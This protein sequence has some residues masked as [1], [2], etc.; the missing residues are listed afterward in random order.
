M[1]LAEDLEKLAALRRSGALTP[2]EF[3]AAKR[4]L[5]SG[6]APPSPPSGALNRELV[7]AIH[8]FLDFRAL[9]GLVGLLALLIVFFLF[10]LPH[11]H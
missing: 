9:F 8:R 5:L 10:I 4:Q 6:S 1:S 2:E 3:S 11:F 7:E